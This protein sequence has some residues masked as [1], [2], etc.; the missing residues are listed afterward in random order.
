[1]TKAIAHGLAALLACALLAGCGGDGEGNTSLEQDLAE[2]QAQLAA[3]EAKAAEEAAAKAAAEK[4]AADAAALKAAEEAAAKKA[5]EEAAAKKARE[6]AIKKA[7]EEEAAKQAARIAAL[8]KAVEA[9]TKAQEEAEEEEEE[10]EDDTAATASTATTTATTTTATTTATTPTTTTTTTTQTS[11]ASTGESVRRA[12]KILAAFDSDPATPALDFPAVT[13]ESLTDTSTEPG[14]SVNTAGT[15]IKI[16]SGFYKAKS[17]LASLTGFHGVLL[18][19]DKGAS[20]E[21]WAIYTDIE[22]KRDVL[23][24]YFNNRRVANKP[25]VFQFEAGDIGGMY[26]TSANKEVDL[27]SISGI[28]VTR[29]G[30]DTSTT[31]Y[32]RVTTTNSIFTTVDAAAET[33]TITRAPNRSFSA[34]IR[35]RPGTFTC[36]SATTDCDFTVGTTTLDHDG[37]AST[38]VITVLG[39]TPFT[40]TA[41]EWEFKPSSQSTIAIPGGDKEFMYFGWWISTPDSAGGEYKFIPRIGGRAL[42]TSH[43]AFAATYRGSATGRYVRQNRAETITSDGEQLTRASSGVFTATASLTAT[44][45]GVVTGSIADFKEG[46]SSLGNWRVGL[47]GSDATS[48]TVGDASGGTGAWAAQ[49]V[50]SRVGGTAGGAPPGTATEAPVAAVGH[51]NAHLENVLS[52]SGAF[53]ATRQLPSN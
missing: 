49:Y 19:E 6:D 37:A 1:M 12:H 10:V 32:R 20:S 34:T 42:L 16:S 23:E 41:T 33:A 31:E 45:A 39:G 18:E 5:A 3:I 46:G 36:V 9:L 8:T 13:F 27:F 48:L 14:I 26:T 47:D 35:G 29:T 44:S 25:S 21:T 7:Q 11:T 4:A 51:F 17:G 28:D 50:P 40:F 24:H 52:L 38:P 2:A 43:P 22:R 53:G 30:T 15:S